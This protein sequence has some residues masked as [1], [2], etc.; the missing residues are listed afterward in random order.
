MGMSPSPLVGAM[1]G[2]EVNVSLPWKVCGAEA[3]G[4]VRLLAGA[5]TADRAQV[6]TWQAAWSL[7]LP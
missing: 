3:M 5:S 2:L 1:A 4:M 7:I 6:A